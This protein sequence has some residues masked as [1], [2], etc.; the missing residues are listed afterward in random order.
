MVNALIFRALERNTLGVGLRSEACTGF[1]FANP[2][3]AAVQQ[4]QDAAADGAAAENKEITL[5]LAR[6]IASIG[7]DPLDA[8]DSGTFQPGDV[9]DNTFRGNSCNELN[10]E[11]AGLEVYWIET[12]DGS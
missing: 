12:D 4:H 3:V 5:E 9:N 6:Q 2:E 10:G 11:L 1:N 7:G 8:L